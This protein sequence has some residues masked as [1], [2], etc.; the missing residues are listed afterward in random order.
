[1][2]KVS[3]RQLVN[4]SSYLKLFNKALGGPPSMPDCRHAAHGLWVAM[5]SLQRDYIE[6]PAIELYQW[7]RRE[8]SITYPSGTMSE[9]RFEEC[10]R[11]H[12]LYAIAIGLSDN[13]NGYSDVDIEVVAT[14]GAWLAR[15][16]VEKWEPTYR[17]I[18]LINAVIFNPRGRAAMNWS[19]NDRRMACDIAIANLMES[20]LK[21]DEAA[22]AMGMKHPYSTFEKCLEDC[23]DRVG[24]HRVP[25]CSQ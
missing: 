2:K 10:K 24:K 16:L 25:L 23:K 15:R 12:P 18:Q 14:V 4:R 17:Q 5:G 7:R 1:M 3:N 6:I 8:G 11:K 20:V 13:D 22:K 19:R 21:N 9:Y